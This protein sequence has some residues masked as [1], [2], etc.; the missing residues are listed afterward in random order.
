MSETFDS[1]PHAKCPPV[2]K[3]YAKLPAS[4]SKKQTKHCNLDALTQNCRS[5]DQGG[6]SKAQTDHIKDTKNVIP[7][8]VPGTIII[9]PQG[10]RR[11]EDLKE[12]DRVITRDNGVQRILW[13]GRRD[14]T[15]HELVSDPKMQ[16]VLI[17]AGSLGAEL[18][19]TDMMVSPNHRL[20]M[21][22]KRVQTHLS[23]SEVLAAAK[24]LVGRDGIER[25]TL[26]KASYIHI[27]FE[28][29]ELIMSDGAWTESF[30]PNE[31]TLQG[32]NQS[33]RKEIYELFPELECKAG[34]DDYSAAR[35]TVKADEAEQIT[36]R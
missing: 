11:V 27:L 10:E 29:H 25:A 24:H 15:G 18:P 13:T 33:Q 14:F 1:Q 21:G 31:I 20:L 8:F 5:I 19:E 7:C 30:Q 36:I 6:D 9:T 26:S 23:E 16:P 4:A 22:G 35:Y 12:G 3:D 17:K 2:P 28:H 32:F 34:R